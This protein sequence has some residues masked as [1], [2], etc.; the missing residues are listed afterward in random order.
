MIEALR[1]SE[2][3]KPD[4]DAFVGNS[5]NGTFLFLRDYMDYHA[6]RFMDASLLLRQDRRLVAIMPAN[7]ASREIHSH[8]GLSFGGL[9]IDDHVSAAQTTEILAA[10][11]AAYADEGAERLVYR[12]IPHIYHRAPAQDDLYALAKL[13]AQLRRRDVLS[14][15][16]GRHRLRWQN[17]RLRGLKRARG[18]GLNVSRSNDWPSYWR[19]LAT[20]L[21]ERHGATPVHSLPEIATLAERFPDNIQLYVGHN[22]DALVGGVVIYVSHTVAHVQYIATNSEGRSSGILDLLFAYLLDD[23]FADKPYF[24]FGSSMGESGNSLNVGLAAH[25]EGFGARTVIQD[26]YAIAIAQ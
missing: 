17:R 25:K 19:L 13:G 12:T 8:Q 18:L 23:V 16:D 24:D 7:Q 3:D 6:D 20:C 1:Y 22:G 21:D 2:A 10:A 15:V 26:T 9:V 4:W 5:R 11:I 14:V